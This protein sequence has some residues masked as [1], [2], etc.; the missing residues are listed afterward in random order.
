MCKHRVAL[1]RLL[2]LGWGEGKATGLPVVGSQGGHRRDQLGPG[3]LPGSVLAAGRC[4]WPPQQG[5]QGYINIID[6][7]DTLS[8]FLQKPPAPGEG[9]SDDLPSIPLS[10]ASMLSSCATVLYLWKHMRRMQVTPN[11]SFSSPRLQSQWRV[12][13]TGI[14]QAVLYLFCSLWFILSY[15]LLIFNLDHDYIGHILCTVICLL[16]ICTNINLGFGQ[17]LFRQRVADL[18]NRAVQIP[19]LCGLNRA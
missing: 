11:S 1:L 8:K 10:E 15:L 9:T 14:I 4:A 18:W 12:T 7:E 13:I 16:S 19:Q 5:V 3:L 6:T 2:D 17:T